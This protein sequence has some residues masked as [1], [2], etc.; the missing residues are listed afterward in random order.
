MDK[1]ISVR[2]E[3]EH[4]LDFYDACRDVLK[5]EKD[6]DAHY[7]CRRI[8][9]SPERY[10]ILEKAHS[11]AGLSVQAFPIKWLMF[12]PK[13]NTELFGEVVKIEEGFIV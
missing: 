3:P 2:L 8:E 10:N 6:E 11:D 5:P 7:D 9:V 1:Y 4:I 12:G 13:I